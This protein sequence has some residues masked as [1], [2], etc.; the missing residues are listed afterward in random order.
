MKGGVGK[1]TL[2]ANIT[3]AMAD[4]AEPPV[5]GRGKKF[6]LIDADAQCNLSQTFL[7]S[8]QLENHSSRSVFQAFQAS[9]RQYGPSDLKTQVYQNHTNKASIDLIVGSFETFGLVLATPKH[10]NAASAAFEQFMKQARQEYD[11]IV[12]DTNPSATF[13]TLQALEVSKFLVAPI[14]FDRF[15]MRGIDLITR[16]LKGRYE[17]LQNPRRIRL[18]P[19]KVRRASDDGA[20]ARQEQDERDVVEKFPELEESLSLNR[21]H[22]SRFLDNRVSQRG[23]GFVVD[24][25]VLAMNRAAHDLV[26]QD[27]KA[28]ASSIQVALNEAFRDEGKNRGTFIEAISERVDVLFNRPVVRH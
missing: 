19:N 14:T 2:A 11:V 20:R 24:Q 23:D 27:F 9:H 28:A 8:D 25:R 4:L 6:L 5:E 17:W 10:Q 3:R 1:T 7:N 16:T 13:T 18:V 22:E 15:A 26:V 12:I 21:I